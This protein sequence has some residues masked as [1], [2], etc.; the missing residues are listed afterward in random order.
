[1]NILQENTIK[2]KLQDFGPKALIGPIV[3]KKISVLN[4][5]SLRQDLKN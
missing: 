3:S 1:V 2:E 4:L 5:A